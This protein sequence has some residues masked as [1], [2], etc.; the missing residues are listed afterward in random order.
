MKALDNFFLSGFKDASYFERRKA[1]YLFYIILSA[2]VFMIYTTLGQ[3]TFNLGGVYLLANSLALTGIICALYY[4]KRGRIERAGHFMACSVLGTIILQGSGH[5]IFFNDPAMRFRLYITAVS[6]FGVCFLV[7]SFF[8]E[9]KFVYIY[10]TGF[11]I[12]LF[13][14]ALVIAHQLKDIPLMSLYVWQHFISLSFGLMVIAAICTWL[15]SYMEALFQQNLE[16]SE[17]VKLQKEQLEVMVEERTHALR[18]SNKHLREFAY[19]VSHDL[20]EP[21]RTI[22][23]FVTLIKRDLEKLGL[24]EGEIEEYLGF[25]TKGTVHMEKLI[26]DILAYSKLNV[27]EMKLHETNMDE[28]IANA[29]SSL[30]KSIYESEAEILVTGSASVMGEKVLLEQL[31]Q[32]LL[33]NAIK[34]RSNERDLKIVIGCREKGEKVE[35]FIQDNGIGIS[36]EYFDTIFKAFRRLHSKVDHEGTGVGLAIC[37]KIMDIHGGDLWVESVVEEGST[38]LFTL[39]KTHADVRASQPVVHAA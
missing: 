19:I 2:F 37:K 30:A 5:D 10:G 34:Y 9:K 13:V 24:N 16:F 20:K 32:N 39:P 11:E 33:S 14:H 22:S 1:S 35:Y 8:R 12:V 4:F 21:L 17:R 23:G 7:I 6:L 3:L 29:K 25:V 15:L 26:S 27:V 28:V 18:T 38:F 31:L 36:E